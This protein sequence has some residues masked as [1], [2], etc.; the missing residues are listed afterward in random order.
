MG[1][2]VG[3]HRSFARCGESQWETCDVHYQRSVLIL[4]LQGL[5]LKLSL[6]PFSYVISFFLVYV[7]EWSEVKSGALLC[8]NL[9]ILLI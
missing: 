1:R 8:V 3:W 5:K 4:F 6:L 9:E 7:N 2:G